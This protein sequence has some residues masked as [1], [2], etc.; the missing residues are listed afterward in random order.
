[1]REAKDRFCWCCG[2]STGVYADHDR[3]DTCGKPDCEREVRGAYAQERDEAHE[4]LD[5]N[6][7][8]GGG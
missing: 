6:V 8:G 4:E 1:M 5:R 2:E 3:M 7:Y